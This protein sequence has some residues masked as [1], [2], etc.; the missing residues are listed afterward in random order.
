MMQAHVF[1]I[2]HD[3][4]EWGDT[5]ASGMNRYTVFLK[6]AELGSLTRAAQA[7]HYTQSGVSHA[8]AALE[9]EV[10][11]PL[12]LRTGYGVTLTHAGQ[13]LLPAI[14]QLENARLGLEQTIS[15]LSSGVSGTLRLGTISSVSAG[16]LPEIITRFERLYPQVE[17]APRDGEYAAVTQWIEEGQVDCGFLTAPV[18]VP[19]YFLPMKRDPMLAVLPF[20]HPLAQREQI[21]LEDLKDEPIL[22]ETENWERDMRTAFGTLPPLKL[23]YLLSSA[24][25]VLAM[26]EKGLGVTICPALTVRSFG[27][28]SCTLPLNPPCY[29]TLG[30]AS[31]SPA[32]LSPVA[33]TFLN[34]LRETDISE[35]EQA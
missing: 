31:L 6:A 27:F 17:I 16:W 34:F 26:V 23:R 11:T 29:R 28:R 5:M 32:R 35:L 14:R 13:Q 9:Q 3:N 30:I 7:L 1:H 21:T 24:A 2:L 15:Q 12:F 20:G 33:R 10:G 18:A 22:M 4:S 25:A 8:I 19:L